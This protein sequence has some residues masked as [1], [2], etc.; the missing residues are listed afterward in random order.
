[1]IAEDKLTFNT[2]KTA[3]HFNAVHVAVISH[4]KI[5]HW[6]TFGVHNQLVTGN[7]S[8]PVHS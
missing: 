5:Q 4:S 2:H 3:N 6:R 7:V 8:N 1:M